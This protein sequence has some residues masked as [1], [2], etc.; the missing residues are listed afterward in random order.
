MMPATPMTAAALS[1][2][3]RRMRPPCWRLPSYTL[4]SERIREIAGAIRRKEADR[5]RKPQ[6][7]GRRNVFPGQVDSLY[8]IKAAAMEEEV[9]NETAAVRTIG[10][11]CIFQP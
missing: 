9:H 3:K 4:L 7:G 5:I 11:A 1:F 8:E 2:A 10:T 6:R